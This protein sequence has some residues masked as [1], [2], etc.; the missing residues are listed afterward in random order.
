MNKQTLNKANELLDDINNINKVLEAHAGRKW[1]AFKAPNYNSEI[2]VSPRLQ[3]ELA[4]FLK[5]KQ[6]Q[7]YK[8][9]EEL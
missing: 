1:I 2:F 9:L 4:E 8:E 5:Q 3:G 7:Y 6:G